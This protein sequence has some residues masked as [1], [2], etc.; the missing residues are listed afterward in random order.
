MPM[1]TVLGDYLPATTVHSHPSNGETEQ[2]LNIIYIWATPLVLIQNLFF[3]TE[4]KNTEETRYGILHGLLAR[5][6]AT[7]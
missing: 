6:G 5:W 1:E 2:L 3:C 7:A 4:E